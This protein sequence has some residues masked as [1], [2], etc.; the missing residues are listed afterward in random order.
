MDRKQEEYP[1][2]S[3]PS[4]ILLALLALCGTA[5]AEGGTDSFDILGFRLGMTPD[6]AAQLAASAWA[7]PVQATDLDPAAIEALLNE[8]AEQLSAPLSEEGKGYSYYTYGTD[9]LLYAVGDLDGD[10]RP[11][12]AARAVYFMGVGSYDLVDIFA[13]RGDGYE[14]VD[15][16][17]LYHLGLEDEVEDGKQPLP[18]LQDFRT[19]ALRSGAS[20]SPPT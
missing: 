18:D 9:D 4:W 2:M 17:N 1:G 12:I 7:E 20:L 11:E 3:S 13:D 6:E 10:G 5:A 19:E 8:T 15:F 14:R 16:L